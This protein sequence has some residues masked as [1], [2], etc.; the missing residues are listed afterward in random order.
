MNTNETTN[1]ILEETTSVN[2]QL[3]ETTEK[4][5]ET[6]LWAQIK[7]N[8]KYIF[9]GVGIVA[10]AGV[11]YSFGSKKLAVRFPGMHE[12]TVKQLPKKIVS[13][14]PVAQIEPVVLEPVVPTRPYT[15]PIEPFVVTWHVR[16]MAEWKHHSAAKA[17]QAAEMGIELAS[18]QTIVNSYPKYVA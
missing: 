10:L 3:T 14:V 13:T 16:D 2:P 6:S 17:S 15:K 5:P 8:K 12:E 7:A 9:A 4:A 1:Q 11:A 18:N